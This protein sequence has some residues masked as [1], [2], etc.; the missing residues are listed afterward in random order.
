MTARFIVFRWTPAEREPSRRGRVLAAKLNDHEW[1]KMLDWRGVLAFVHAD[2]LDDVMVLP[3]EFGFVAGPLFAREGGQQVL[4][5]S[6][7]EAE[8]LI[9]TGASE[10]F[11]RYWGPCCAILHN[12]GYDYFHAVRDPAGSNP[13]Y[14]WSADR[15][16]CLFTHVDDF[17]TCCDEPVSCDEG[18]L[19][20]YMV[21]PRILTKRTAI[22][23]VEELLAGERLT[24]G[25]TSV[26][27][28]FIWRP[29]RSGRPATADFDQ[30]RGALRSAVMQ[31]ATSWA[32]YNDR[33]GARPIAHRLSGGLD[34][35]IVLAALRNAS[36]TE[37]VCFHEYPEATPE[38]DER[39]FARAA[40]RHAGCEL[41][42]YESRAGKFDYE[43][44]LNEPLPVRP[45]H[46]EFSHANRGLGDAIAARGAR[47]V[48]SGQGGDQV[49]HRRRF[50]E[51]AAD[52]AF[53]RVGLRRYFAIAQDTARLARVPIWSV[54]A[55]TIERLLRHQASFLNSAFTQAVL[56]HS[57]AIELAEEE[58]R[59]HPMRRELLRE[60]PARTAR[61]LHIGDLSYYFEV[62]EITRRFETA[63]ILASL[64]VIE[65]ILAVPPYVMTEGGVDRALAR[66]AFGDL[67]PDKI[68]ERSH[69]GDTTRFH[70]RVLERQ[71]PLFREFLLDGELARRRL[72]D[73][74]AV[75]RAL[76]P[77][78]VA[79][80]AIKGALMSAFMA[81]AWLQ[82]FLRRSAPYLEAN[83]GEGA[84]V[85]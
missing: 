44:I 70:N 54:F 3:A 13:I 16:H 5:M 40:A 57:G 48:T 32:Q 38:G 30:A 72:I 47:V 68:V 4:E 77:G 17:L 55:K 34:S 61:A 6:S 14:V 10:L 20:I 27:R 80:G 46:T 62:S 65:T 12:R 42:E 85:G 2:S 9:T 37:V 45:T 50:A 43:R 75:E 18:M 79:N 36:D 8:A 66:A 78:L 59:D 31:S 29:T 25:R 63:P 22:K 52:A 60:T 64:P 19:G 76:K 51:I 71:M 28:K 67:L 49:L 33:G 23:G 24:L 7:V 56:A 83:Q 53:D 73:R 1:K 11:S 69:K 15:L 39:V 21:Q 84:A 82:R 41:V 58:W 35:S 81:E 74:E 26:E